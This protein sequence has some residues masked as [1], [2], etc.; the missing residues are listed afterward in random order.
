MTIKEK[1]AYLLWKD[2]I[3]VVSD[4]G[5]WVQHWSLLGRIRNTSRHIWRS[6]HWFV[7]GTFAAICAAAATLITSKIAS[8]NG[9]T[10]KASEENKLHSGMIRLECRPQKGDLLLCKKSVN[11]DEHRVTGAEMDAFTNSNPN[12]QPT[13]EPRQDSLH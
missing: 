13:T 9:H 10:S 2:R 1:I 12:K 4:A 7:T 5:D 11:G 3:E 6:N 8:D